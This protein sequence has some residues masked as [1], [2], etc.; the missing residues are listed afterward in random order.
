MRRSARPAGPN[1]VSLSC[2]HHGCSTSDDSMLRRRSST[3]GSASR[4]R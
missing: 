2:R 3:S 1:R 4:S